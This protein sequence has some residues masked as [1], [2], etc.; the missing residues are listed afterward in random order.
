MEILTLLMLIRRRRK[1]GHELDKRNKIFILVISSREKK[2]SI[3]Y[4]Y[5]FQT[6]KSNQPLYNLESA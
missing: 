2:L 1:V 4:S 3:V 6:A 5:R